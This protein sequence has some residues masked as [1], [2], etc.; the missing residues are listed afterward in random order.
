[1]ALVAAYAMAGKMKHYRAEI[2]IP[3]VV[4]LSF[5]VAAGF[6]LISQAGG[7]G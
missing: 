3:V 4:V 6:S 7:G 5:V 2:T 1:M